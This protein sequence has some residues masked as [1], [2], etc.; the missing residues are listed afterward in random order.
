MLDKLEKRRKGPVSQLVD[1]VIVQVSC[2]A[3]HQSCEQCSVLAVVSRILPCIFK[4]ALFE[5]GQ[6]FEHGYS[7]PV[8][9]TQFSLRLRAVLSRLDAHSYP[10]RGLRYLLPVATNIFSARIWTR[11]GDTPLPSKGWI[12][13][14]MMFL[15]FSTSFQLEDLYRTFWM[16]LMD[17]IVRVHGLQPPSLYST[18]AKVRAS[19]CHAFHVIH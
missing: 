16:L 13:F 7:R 4:T 18:C 3:Q 14:G 8:V 15:C 6:D 11:T 1:Q 10:S 2:R 12:S 5:L 19:L 17:V 9:P